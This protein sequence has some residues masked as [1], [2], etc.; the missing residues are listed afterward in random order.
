MKN[1]DYIKKLTI[2]YREIYDNKKVPENSFFA[3]FLA[4]RSKL[5]IELDVRYTKG[6]KIVVFH[7]NSLHRM[8][9]INKKVSE[10]T[11]DEIKGFP[12][13]K[14]SYRAPLLSEVLSLINGDVLINIEIK[15]KIL[16]YV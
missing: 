14:T 5:P 6:K 2:V 11:F 3:F 9:Q 7:D 13:I 15:E 16:I 4:K 12:L 8:T 1:I 10:C